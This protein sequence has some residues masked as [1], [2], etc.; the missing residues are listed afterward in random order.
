M[1]KKRRRKKKKGLWNLIKKHKA[2]SAVIALFLVCII[3]VAGVIGTI[4]WNLYH[5]SIGIVDPDDVDPTADKVQIAREDP[6]DD[7]V[8]NVLLVGSDSRDP[9][10]EMGAVGYN[11]PCVL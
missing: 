6:K 4:A 1:A 7:D 3:V 5:D 11:D 2:A 9:N 8:I 10:A